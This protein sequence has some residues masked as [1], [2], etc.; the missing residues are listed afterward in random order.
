MQLQADKN[1]RVLYCSIVV[2]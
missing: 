2:W 1:M